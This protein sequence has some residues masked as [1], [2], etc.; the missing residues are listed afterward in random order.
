V[1]GLDQRGTFGLHRRGDIG[2]DRD[3]VA[4]ATDEKQAECAAHRRSERDNGEGDEQFCAQPGGRSASQDW[5][6]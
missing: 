1:G 2:V 4:D 5:G 6:H 3:G